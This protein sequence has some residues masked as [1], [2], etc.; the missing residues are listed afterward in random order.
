LPEANT[1]AV[2]ARMK[3]ERERVAALVRAEGAQAATVIRADADKDRTVLLADA[4]S[5]ALEF[6]GQGQA[7]ATT[8]LAKAYGKDPGFFKIWRTL[9]A[10]RRGLASSSTELLLSPESPLLRYLSVPPEPGDTTAGH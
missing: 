3:T 5:K 7:Q 6:K 1:Q 9:D 8:I 2:L 10:Y 4:K